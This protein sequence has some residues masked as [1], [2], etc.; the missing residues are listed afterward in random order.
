MQ[1]TSL[2]SLFISELKDL[3]SAETQLLDALPKMAN[4]ATHNELKTAFR[5]HLEETRGQVD[6]LERVFRQLGETPGGET[7]EAMKGLIK[8]GEEIIGE[9]GNSDVKD[10]ALIAA[11][12]RV[13]HYEIAGYGTVVT[14]AKK[15]DLDDVADLLGKTLDQEKSADSKLNKLATGGVF[16]GGINEEAMH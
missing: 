6:R 2:R 15:L 8:E 3:Y 14:Y 16:A 12:Q 1:L 7:C 4:A 11:A 13:E 10:A 5:D 9:E